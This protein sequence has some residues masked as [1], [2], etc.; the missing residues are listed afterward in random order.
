MQVGIDEVGRGCLAGPLVIG[1][2]ILSRPIEGLKDS[3][4]LSKN[5][6]EELNLIIY[7]EARAAS[8]GWVW[9]HEID[10]LGLTKATTLAINRALA[11]IKVDYSTVLIDGG[12]NYLKDN[13]KAITMIKA[14][15]LVPEVS[16]A[17]I[18]AKVARDNYMDNISEYFPQYSFTKHVGYG[19]SLHIDAITKFGPCVLHR[20][21]FKP[22]TSLV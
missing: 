8:L 2:V 11:L 17:S 1:A 7:N 12:F 21:S 14:D 4:L 13:P 9:P 18:I 6:R 3:K 10:S 22:L 20:L 5:K 19:T 15:N 16:A